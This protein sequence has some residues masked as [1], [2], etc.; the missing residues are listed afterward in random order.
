VKGEIAGGAARDLLNQDFNPTAIICVNDV[1]AV[2]ALQELRERGLLVPEDVS[3]TGFDN[4]TLSQFYFP[5]LTTVHI[6][7]DRIAH[8]VCHNLIPDPHKTPATGSEIIIDP[9]LVV[10]K[11][12]GPVT[13]NQG[14]NSE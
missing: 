5:P 3:V 2:G 14:G 13:P 1:M 9:Q 8:I 6:P 11:C 7:R 12:T 4:I 10:R